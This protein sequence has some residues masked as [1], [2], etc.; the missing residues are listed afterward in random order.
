M[1]LEA[2]QFMLKS[3]IL[4]SSVFIIFVLIN[5]CSGPANKESILNPNVTPKSTLKNDFA[6]GIESLDCEK[7]KTAFK[8]MKKIDPNNDN[9]FKYYLDDSY[10]KTNSMNYEELDGIIT[11]CINGDVSNDVQRKMAMASQAALDESLEDLK[12]SAKTGSE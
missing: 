7:A 11:S 5:G 9:P 10:S 6:M 4:I 3:K 12:K 2:K 1:I 8:E